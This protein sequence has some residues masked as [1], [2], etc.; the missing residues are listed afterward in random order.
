M[1]IIVANGKRY[2]WKIGI[3][4]LVVITSIVSLTIHRYAVSIETP[5]AIVEIPT[6][7]CGWRRAI[8]CEACANGW[9]EGER[10][11]NGDCRWFRGRCVPA[12]E[13]LIGHP[14]EINSSGFPY[15]PD[16]RP[17]GCREVIDDFRSHRVS[18]IIPWLKEKWEHMEGT[19]LALLHFTPPN[20]IEEIIFVSDG[21]KDAREGP[22]KA[23][24]KK[25]KV[26][27]LPERNGLIRAKMEGVAIAKAP[28]LVFLEAH[29]IVNRDWLQ[30]LLQR[31]ILNPR[32]LAMPSLDVIPAD[33][34]HLYYG[35]QHGHWRYEWN[36]NL[37]FSTPDSSANT[38]A[39]PY[40]SPGTSGGVFAM[41]RDW[42]KYLGL[43]DPFMLEWGGDHFELT[44]K[45]WRC[46]GRIEIVPCSRIGH[47]FREV[48]DRP[49]GVSEWQVV[50][51][52]ARL[53]KV[54]ALE[55]LHLFYKVKPNAR[56]MFLGDLTE[57]RRRFDELQCRSLQWYIE[58]IDVEMGWEAD[59]LCLWT[60][61]PA[62]YYTWC[63]K[64]HPPGRSTIEA[65]MNQGDYVKA[66]KAADE[67][68]KTEPF[69]PAFGY[70]PDTGSLQ[71]L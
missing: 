26:I 51:N 49:Y 1:P 59:R 50:H 12:A 34:W 11:C 45:V 19:M 8:S 38:G 42:F 6:V 20:L 61:N 40:M 16:T 70:L 67:R 53:A 28:V 65:V 64:P 41:R 18:I 5:A 60:W 68:L 62:L 23:L 71:E 52:Y 66:R 46:G 17:A 47:L 22:L 56:F 30:P 24:S 36:F 33:D 44:M 39:M 7:S 4:I 25:V 32:A 57:Q 69:A 14:G 3:L 2:K 27:A 55:Y 13:T 48:K 35:S 54:W 15:P 43:F 21:N 9:N 37:I 58:N 63:K 29:V 31:L 10:T